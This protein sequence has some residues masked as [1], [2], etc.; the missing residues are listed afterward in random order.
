MRNHNAFPL[1]NERHMTQ[2][3][4]QENQ[5]LSEVQ[6]QAGKQE[7]AQQFAYYS[8]KNTFK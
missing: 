5:T 6:G 2:N 3:Y 8:H 7:T 4:P 1:K